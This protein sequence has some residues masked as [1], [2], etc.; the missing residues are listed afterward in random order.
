VLLEHLNAALSSYRQSLDLTP[1][2]D[3]E[4]RAVAEN[5]LGNTYTYAGDTR[6]ALR[7]YQQSIHH[8]ETRGDL[9]GAGITRYNI[10][11][12]LDRADRVGDALTYARAAVETFQR[13]GS[14]AAADA[15]DARQ[16]VAELER[17][18]R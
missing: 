16:F 1:A 15:D 3:H 14:G 6:Q 2:D 4:Q 13:A 17:R 11:I 7:H 9:F 5:Q 8:K 12:L 18:G 10:A